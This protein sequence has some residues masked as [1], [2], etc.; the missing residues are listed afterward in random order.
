L[1][2]VLS[3]AGEKTYQVDLAK[4]TCTCPDRAK[5]NLCKHILACLLS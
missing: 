3:Q 4:P 2:E 5:G 1:F